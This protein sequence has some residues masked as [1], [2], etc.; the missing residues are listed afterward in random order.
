[1]PYAQIGD[2]RL[3][4][5]DVGSGFPLI[6]AHEFGGS[7]ESWEAQ[8]H[9]FSRRY[10]VITFNMRGYPP[11]DVPTDP[12]VYSE[13]Q[14]TDDIRGVLLHLGIEQAYVGG[15]SMGATAALHF[16]RRYPEMARAIIVA[17]AGTGATDPERFRRES[18]ELAGRLETQGIAAMK[19]Y[20][21]GETRVQLRRKD[22]SGWAI[23][24]GLIQKHD[25]VGSALTLRGVQGKRE[26]VFAYE[27]ELRRVDVPALILVGDEDEPC[28]DASV[29]LKRVM[30]R[31]GL[32]V[33]PQSGHAINLEEP[34]LFNRH[35]SEFLSAVE[36]GRWYLRERGSG[37]GF[38]TEKRD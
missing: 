32:V 24:D 33:L 28:I 5:E 10:R 9:Y 36:A 26:P 11:S 31:A 16:G 37:G 3:A 21:L 15:I 20:A 12:S 18:N 35:V 2:V 30:P 29:F 17:G 22:P 4:Y 23:F 38:M 13:E 25:A 19:D 34:E 8:V 7:M 14:A 27:E 6:L 1:M